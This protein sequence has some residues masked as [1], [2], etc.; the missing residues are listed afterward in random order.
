MN[1]RANILRRLRRFKTGGARYVVAS[2]ALAYVSVG[3]VPCA[4]AEVEVDSDAAAVREHTAAQVGHAHH[5]HE[6]HNVAAAAN[7][8]GA[9]TDDGA[10]HC[11]HCLAGAAMAHAVE[12]SSCFA[13]EDLTNVAASHAKDV[14]Q[15]LAPSF[16]PAPFTLPPP[17][18]SPAASPPSHAAAVPSVPLNVRHCVYLI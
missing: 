8:A 7:G 9:P 18:A 17:L 15:P 6:A 10:R 12:H 11:P 2:F 14:P 4:A 5:G 16:G 13:L 1:R 3:I